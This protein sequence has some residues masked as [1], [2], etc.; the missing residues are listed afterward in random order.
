MNR[1]IRK[2]KKKA[3]LFYLATKLG[4]LLILL[5][6]K[7]N[8]IKLVGRHYIDKLLKNKVPLIFVL[9]HG[10]ILIPIYVHRNEGII[11]M[12]SLH[13][14]GEMI[15]QALHKLGYQTVRGSSTRGGKK[16][17][18]DM[19]EAIARGKVGTMIPDGPRGPRHQLKPGTLYIAQQTG[20]CLVPVSY[21]A[22]R[23]IIFNSWDRFMLP[24]PFSKCV[25][26]YGKPLQIPDNLS[27]VQLEQLRKKFEKDLIDLESHADQYFQ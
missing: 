16:A 26:I 14:D 7:L 3:I 4:W 21:S 19:V 6:G 8:F 10:R 12:V 13:S 25:M 18:H 1:E 27:Q 17:F 20:A 15:A 9:W 23:K 2:K 24:L 22:K 5:L 11:P